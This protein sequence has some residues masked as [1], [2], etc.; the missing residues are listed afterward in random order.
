[1][2]PRKS[3]FTRDVLEPDVAVQVSHQHVLCPPLL[4]WRKSATRMSTYHRV[5]VFTSQMG[6]ERQSD[7]VQK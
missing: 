6:Y 2:A 3:A 1:M 7:M 5:A 4:E